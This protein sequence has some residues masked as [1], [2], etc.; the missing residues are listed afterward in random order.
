MKNDDHGPQGLRPPII[1]YAPFRRSRVYTGTRETGSYNHHSQLAC[2][3][4][5]YCF[6]WSNGLVDEE[7]EGQRI[8]IAFSPD[9]CSWG[10]AQVVIGGEQGTT[11]VHN[12]VALH[13]QADA[14][15][16]IDWRSRPSG[17]PK[18]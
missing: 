2:H 18:L 16:L 7:A 10:E 11:A 17:M 12:C 13:S 6:A 14:L 3:R 1:P 4:G 5:R 8:L 15:Y 9:G